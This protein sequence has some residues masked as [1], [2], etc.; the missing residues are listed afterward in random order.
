MGEKD[1][2]F[3]GTIIKDTGTITTVGAEWKQGR[4]VGRVGVVGSGGGGKGRKL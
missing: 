4:E 2:G 3:I 1:E